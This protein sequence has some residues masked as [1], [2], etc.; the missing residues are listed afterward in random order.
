MAAV[1]TNASGKVE[2]CDLLE[3][4]QIWEA[5]PASLRHLADSA[6]VPVDLRQFAQ[7]LSMYGEPRAVE[8][9][10]QVLESEYPGWAHAYAWELAHPP[11]RRR[12][13]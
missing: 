6:P 8:L 13:A 1:P 3:Q 9:I 7:V 2:V 4:M 10:S 11:K 12:R 5:L